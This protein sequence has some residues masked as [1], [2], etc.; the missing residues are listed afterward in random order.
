MDEE[1]DV[2]ASDKEGNVIGADD[3]HRYL[4]G[5]VLRVTIR[6]WDRTPLGWI[7]SGLHIRGF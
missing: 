3:I 6:A 2:D 5:C 4:C 7:L 1:G